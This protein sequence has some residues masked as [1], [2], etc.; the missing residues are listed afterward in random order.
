MNLHEQLMPIPLLG[1]YRELP[2]GADTWLR[3]SSDL[4]DFQCIVAAVEACEVVGLVAIVE[5]REEGQTGRRLIN[6]LRFR[7]LK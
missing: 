1:I 5:I 6:A 7:R 4:G 3:G 2:I